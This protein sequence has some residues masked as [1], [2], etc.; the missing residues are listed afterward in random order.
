MLSQIAMEQGIF[1]PLLVC[2][3]LAQSNPFW[4]AFT[5]GSAAATRPGRILVERGVDWGLAW[6]AGG[7][8]TP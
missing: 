6:Q 4:G 7:D 3:L 8:L 1:T 5:S 2:C